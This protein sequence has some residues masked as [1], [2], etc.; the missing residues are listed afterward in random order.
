M[1]VFLKRVQFSLF[2][3]DNSMALEL[4][5][6]SLSISA[7]SVKGVFLKLAVQGLLVHVFPLQL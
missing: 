7:R 1:D 6:F 5:H 3:V 4:I 2:A